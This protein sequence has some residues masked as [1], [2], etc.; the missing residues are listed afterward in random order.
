M[1]ADWKVGIGLIASF[2]AREVFNSTLSIIYS[3]EDGDDDDENITRL[4]DRLAEEKRP[5]G[6]PMYTPALCF[7]LMVFFVFAMQ[8]LSTVAVVRRETHG[9]KWPLFQLAYMT[10]TGYLLAIAVFQ[11]G[12]LLGA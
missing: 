7:A 12:R 8:C 4:R 1:G 3:V 2:A 11:I 9:W 6:T 5:D 10:G